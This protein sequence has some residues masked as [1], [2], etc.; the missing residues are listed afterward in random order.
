MKSVIIPLLLVEGPCGT[1]Y[2][3]ALRGYWLRDLQGAGDS[4]TEKTKKCFFSLWQTARRA[5]AVLQP[6]RSAD[7]GEGSGTW[8][9]S[10]CGE[11]RSGSAASAPPQTWVLLTVGRQDASRWMQGP[12]CLKHTHRAGSDGAE[13]PIN[14]PGADVI[15][16]RIGAVYAV[17]GACWQQNGHDWVKLITELL[18]YLAVYQMTVRWSLHH[19]SLWSSRCWC[20]SPHFCSFHPTA[21]LR[22]SYL[23][24]LIT[25]HTETQEFIW[26]ILPLQKHIKVFLFI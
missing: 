17:R 22:T 26:V 2:L 18:L 12:I 24:Y 10:P 8:K 20:I 5:D 1:I 3:C 23:S 11:A 6:P 14:Q 13:P 16:C 15:Y 25:A 19:P 7:R 4:L 21:Q 9:Q